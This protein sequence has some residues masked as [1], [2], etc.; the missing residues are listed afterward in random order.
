[1]VVND[2][3]IEVIGRVL[4]GLCGIHEAKVFVR[5]VSDVSVFWQGYRDPM[6]CENC[7]AERSNSLTFRSS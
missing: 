6:T 1:M 2:G 7:L 5:I 3:Q 4:T